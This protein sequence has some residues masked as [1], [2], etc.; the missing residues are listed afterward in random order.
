M[1]RL[2]DFWLHLSI[3]VKLLLYFFIVIAIISLFNLY[4][5]N[6]NYKIVDQFKD[7]MNNY[8][9]INSLL[10]MTS[11]NKTLV[12]RYL[13]ELDPEDKEN[14]TR[15]KVDLMEKVEDLEAELTSTDAYFII[16][17]IR[18]ASEAMYENWD[19]AIEEREENIPTYFNAFYEGES[20]EVYVISYI[21]EL[22][23]LSLGEGNELYN[24]LAEEAVVMRRISIFL[25][26]I[27][28]LF[29]MFI[30]LFFVNSFINPIKNL[31]SNSMKMAS[32]DLDV[33]PMVI[34]SKDEVGTLS[35]AFNIMS[36]NI[37]QYVDDLKE[38]VV[39][40]KRL[41]EEELEVV[42]MEQLL[43]ES[44][45]EALQS[46]INPHFLFNTLNTISRTAMFEGAEDT[47]KLI[48]ALSNLFR[49]KLKNQSTVINLQEELWIAEEYI[50]LQKFRFK[51]RLTYEIVADQG[52]KSVSVPI[53]MLQPIIENT[54][55]HGIEPKVEGGKIRIKIKSLQ[56]DNK[57]WIILRITDTGVGMTPRRL[58]EVLSFT[59][60]KHHSIGI[61]NVYHRFKIM[62]QHKGS[63]RMMSKKGAGTCV[64]F[65]FERNDLD[66]KI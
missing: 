64:E 40:E 65:K 26:A 42:R 54:I 45:F 47:T 51:E 13:R 41:H 10:V 16:V 37:R 44:Q 15:K 12:S 7:T 25:I 39:I 21:E 48:Q 8:Y 36:H 28:A 19:K 6:N 20:I 22:L 63:F 57:E 34:I 14:Y 38:K 11:E 30:V 24:K 18:N 50:Y 58:K 27:S 66:G 32:G 53:F 49:Y 60:M 55:I 2:K 52:T 23:Y 62:Y 17:A 9:G 46:Q 1:K 56:I 31:A 59:E 33:E 43:R 4:L 5:N 61:S 29:T 3:K 35:D